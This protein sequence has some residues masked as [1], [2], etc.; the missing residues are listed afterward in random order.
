MKKILVPCDFSEQAT[1]AYRQ[2]LDVA[3]KS[4]GVIHLLHV[5]ETPI[6]NDTLL[7]PT[8]NFEEEQMREA[9]S[10]AESQFKDMIKRSKV[11]RVK[12]VS[13]VQLGSIPDTIQ[14][15]IEDHD[16]DLVIMGSTGASGLKEYF[17]GSNAEKVVRH[18]PVPVLILKNYYEQPIRKIVFPNTL[19]TG[20]HED[21]VMKVKELQNFFKAKLCIVYIN[22]PSRF[23]DEATIHK[24]LQQFAKRYMFKDYTTNVYSHTSTEKGVTE[25]TKMVGG[26][27]IAL[28]TH[29]HKGII[30]FVKGS[31]A[32]DIVNH[33][34]RPIWTYRM[35]EEIVENKIK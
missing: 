9:K 34:G 11:E 14:K 20:H 17:I 15:Y 12:S 1:S 21:L 33:T 10:K 6:L 35:K 32:E 19:E 30:H 29:G 18:S 28:G 31:V 7:M 23:E 25:F 2:A 22:I 13:D 16:I 4:G 8:L 27:M 26:D 5:V 24:H 3:A